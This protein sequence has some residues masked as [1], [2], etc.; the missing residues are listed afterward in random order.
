MTEEILKVCNKCRSAKPHSIEYFEAH[1]G[2]KGGLRPVCR[3]CQNGYRTGWRDKQRGGPPRDRIKT[4]DRYGRLVAVARVSPPAVRVVWK[5]QCDCGAACEIRATHVRYGA[6]NSCGCLKAE[7]L[8]A[9]IT[10]HGDTGSPEYKSWQAMISRCE[11]QDNI[12]YWNYG[13]RGISVCARWRSSFEY[14]LEDLGRRPSPTHS[15]DR[16]PNI[17]GNYEPGNVR[18][19]TR[20]QQVRNRRT[21]LFVDWRGQRMPLIEAC[22]IEGVKYSTAHLRLRAGWPIDQVLRRARVAS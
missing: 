13:G 12:S 1:G 19:A 8:L 2:C 7:V 18:W 6:V 5:F 16:F 15:L 9:R 21:T 14:F 11:R 20:S 4:G 22:E 17:D 10:T 3:S